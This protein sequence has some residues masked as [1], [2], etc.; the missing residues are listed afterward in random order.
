[1]TPTASTPDPRDTRLGRL[2][3]PVYWYLVVAAG[4]LLAA[5]PGLVASALVAPV[6]S[7]VPL[8]ALCAVP[9]GPAFSAALYALRDG[10]RGE[11]QNP[12]PRYW[13]GWR[14][15]VIDVLWVWVPV[16][17]IGALIGIG[18][19]FGPAVGVAS[20][21]IVISWIVLLFVALWTVFAIIIASLF[22]F[23]ARDIFRLSLYY[24][25][26]RPLATLGFASLLVLAVAV[27]FFA[28]GWALALLASAFAGLALFTAR[29]VTRDIRERFIAPDEADARAPESP[30]A[31]EAP[32]D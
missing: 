10:T 7:N 25:A 22:S 24:M 9:Y 20:V 8:F 3:T 4:F 27:V 1:M 5:A 18:I 12:W 28:S 26:G 14:L 21:F 15:N 6:V 13:R 11:E 23:R 29:P 31:P 32:E 17:A 16:L 19:A 30:D 2:A